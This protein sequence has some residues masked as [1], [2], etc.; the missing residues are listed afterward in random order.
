S[1]IADSLRLEFK[2][3]IR[4][5]VYDGEVIEPD[6]KTPEAHPSPIAKALV[7]NNFIFEYATQYYY[8]HATIAAATD[9]ALTDNEFNEFVQWL[10]DKDY[11]YKTD[12]EELLEELKEAAEKEQ[13]FDQIKSEFAALAKRLSHDKK[14]DLLK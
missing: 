10:G 12:S 8:K 1:S 4:T 13:Y 3:K 2:T 9:F 6:I 11:S 5:K 14:Q 7:T